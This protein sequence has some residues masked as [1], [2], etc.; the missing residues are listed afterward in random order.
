MLGPV[1]RLKFWVWVKE[2]A[3]FTDLQVTLFWAGVVGFAGA[4][5]S[6]GFRSATAA[7]HTL[8]THDP[9]PSVVESFEHLPTLLRL[10]ISAI[11]SLVAGAIIYFAMR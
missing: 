9:N 6:V 8:L 3:Q 2:R 4:L 7:V 10:L 5:A 11:C 1:R